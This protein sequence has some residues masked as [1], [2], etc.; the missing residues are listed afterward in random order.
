MEGDRVVPIPATTT[1]TL[2]EYWKTHRHP[3]LMFSSRVKI[4]GIGSASKPMS[5]RSI[6]R[7]YQVV[8]AEQKYAKDGIRLHTLRYSYATHLLDGDVNLKVLQQY[9]GHTSLQTTEI[10]LHHTHQRHHG[11]CQTPANGVRF[12]IDNRRWREVYAL[13]RKIGVSHGK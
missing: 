2:R 6:Q 1:C 12:S 4:K 13:T 8:V 5:D 10:H 3:T 9:L 11:Q 7:A